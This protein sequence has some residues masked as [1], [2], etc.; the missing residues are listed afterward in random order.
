MHF[1][2]KYGDCHR[3]LPDLDG[4]RGHGVRQR[5]YVL[6]RRPP[7]G[8]TGGRRHVRLAGY[9]VR[10]LAV[11]FH[12][13]RNVCA[14]HG[15]LWNRELGIKPMIPL[16]ADYPDWHK[17]VVVHNNRVFAVLTMCRWCLR[18]VAPQSRWADRLDGLLDQF[19]DIPLDAM[20]FP[21]NW[22]EC[23]IWAHR[24]SRNT[25]DRRRRPGSGFGR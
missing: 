4:V 5:S 24:R 13:I 20:G 7:Q 1:R 8:E 9:R 17:P 14:H 21:A 3:Y 25:A 22:Q 6:Q 12:T 16:A 10:F 18:R 2:K 15:R 23:P 19:S 11:T